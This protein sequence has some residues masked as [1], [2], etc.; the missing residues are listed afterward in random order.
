M[1]SEK[2]EENKRFFNSCAERYDN[3]LFQFWMK[4]FHKVALQSII[5]KESTILDI[6]CGSGE[7]LAE[8]A[9]RGFRN[10]HGIDLAPSMLQVAKR[11][12]PPDV[13]LQQSDV[14][15]L[16]FPAEMFDY[17]VSTEAFHHYDHQEK[18]L[19]EM[20]RVTKKN[21]QV[22]IADINF[23]LR[24]IHWLFEKFEPGCVK[25][26]NKRKMRKL[27]K[28]VGLN[29]QL[30]QRTFLFAVTTIGVKS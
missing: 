29:V 1:R 26:N 24:P 15:K 5:G 3:T 9:K 25:I 16:P 2:T 12:L 19:Q 7:L 20:K 17:V 22:I 14:H 27:F 28:K 21:G 4:R 10:L 8:L 6:S 18:A 13:K 30:Q 11:K 23:F